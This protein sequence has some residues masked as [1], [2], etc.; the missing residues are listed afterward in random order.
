MPELSL[1]AYD[2]SQL[3]TVTGSPT[4]ALTLWTLSQTT[5]QQ[6]GTAISDLDLLL[7]HATEAERQGNPATAA[8]IRQW[9]EM[10]RAE[11]V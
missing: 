11:Y 10:R 3:P 6:H 9:V 8:F 5:P 7:Q 2:Y 4:P 1:T